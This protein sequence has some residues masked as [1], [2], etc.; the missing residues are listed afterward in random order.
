MSWVVTILFLVM[1]V[2]GGVIN[3]NAETLSSSN[4]K[5]VVEAISGSMA[6]YHSY[7]V[8]YAEANPGVTGSVSDAALGLPSWFNKVAGVSNYVSGGKGYVYYASPPGELAHQLLSDTSNSIF[9]GVKQGGYVI[10]PLS[11][12]S[13]IAVPAAIPDGVVVYAS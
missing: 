4:D 10:N 8:A 1:V 6:V 2:L 12:Q 13:T 5:G 7:V 9:V 3:H 11:G